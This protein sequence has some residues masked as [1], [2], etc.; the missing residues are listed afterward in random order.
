MTVP[1]NTP[2]GPQHPSLTL[3]SSNNIGMKRAGCAKTTCPPPLV[4][5][6]E[7]KILKKTIRAVLKYTFE[8]HPCNLNRDSNL[9]QQLISKVFLSASGGP[10]TKK[11]EIIGSKHLPI[12]PKPI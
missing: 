10:K 3:N 4:F 7:K 12:Q 1:Q 8:N 6:I 2:C 9:D 5:R 11:M